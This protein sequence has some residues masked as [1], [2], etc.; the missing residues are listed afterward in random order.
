MED[1]Q[2]GK[3]R[4]LDYIVF[5]ITLGISAGIGVY[6]W[7]SG[8]KQKTTQVMIIIYFLMYT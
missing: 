1:T 7:F 4:T 2:L 3:F 5:A 6:F 8:G